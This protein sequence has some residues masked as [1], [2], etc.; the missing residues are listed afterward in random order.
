M[1]ENGR[2]SRETEYFLAMYPLDDDNIVD[3]FRNEF[4]WRKKEIQKIVED[5][6]YFY[7]VLVELRKTK[8]GFGSEEENS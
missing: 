1:Q 5:T 6:D 7:S 4:N 2:F 3:S 8:L